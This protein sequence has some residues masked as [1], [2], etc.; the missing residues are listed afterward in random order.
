MAFFGGC[1]KRFNAAWIVVSCF[2]SSGLISSASGHLPADKVYRAFQ[3]PDHLI[4]T[5]DGDLTDWE[6]VDES[7]KISA[8]DF[9]DLV[10]GEE[11]NLADF[12]VHLMIGW[13]RAENKLFVGARVADDIHQIDR[14]SGTAG[15]RIFQDDAVEIFLDAD[16]SGGQYADFSELEP[17]D[18]LLKNGTEASHFVIAGPP[19]EGDFFVHF[20]AASWYA[21][22]DGP[23][24]Q[25]AFHLD[26]KAGG[27]AVMTYELMLVPFD[28][29]D[30]NAVFLS[31]EHHLQEGEVLGFNIEFND[32]DLHS[33]LYDAKWSLSGGH[34][35]FRFSE[36]FTDLI[37]MPLEG[38]FET[39]VGG[40]SWGRIKA[41]FF[42]LTT[43]ESGVE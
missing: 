29:I 12:S 20:S 22:A 30:V 43:S 21:L 17:E 34:N 11:A 38:I 31:D 19:P 35:G 32:F 28:L 15:Y 42:A 41:S 24:S 33:E 18:Q 1:P 27:T 23:F 25:A 26:E 8:H 36:R 40:S 6:L 14:P 16:H 3:F 4:P 2:L 13:N 39:E 5:V 10:D 7:Y 9:R 37:L